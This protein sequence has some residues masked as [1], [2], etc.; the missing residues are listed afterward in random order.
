MYADIF[1]MSLEKKYYNFRLQLKMTSTEFKSNL[2]FDSIH[3]IFDARLLWILCKDLT[4]KG[5]N[6]L[7]PLVY[8]AS[9]R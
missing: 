1:H 5:N 6:K 3:Q 9:I 8:T 7:I 2:D 4:L